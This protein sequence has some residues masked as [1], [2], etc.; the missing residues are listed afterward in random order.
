MPR[1]ISPDTSLDQLKKDAKRW[2]KALRAGDADARRRLDR[3]LP[4]ASA[5]QTRRRAT[6]AA[7]AYGFAMA[8]VVT[9]AVD[10]AAQAT[11]GRE[12]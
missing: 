9:R 8:V 7:R 3:A 6:R 5:V 12:F 4:G 11:L 2:L 10:A 1:T